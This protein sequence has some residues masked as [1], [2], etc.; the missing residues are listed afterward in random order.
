MTAAGRHIVVGTAGHVDHGKTALVKALT[1]IDTDRWEEE[2]RRGITIDLG[3][4]PLRLKDGSL[5]SMVDVPGH[6]DFVRNMVAGATGID[7]A[8]LVVA[9]DEGMMPQTI[10]HL[11][12]VEYLGVQ[13]GVVAVSKADLVEAEWLELVI[14]DVRQ[15]L[16]ASPISWGTPVTVSAKTMVGIEDLR[17]SIAGAAAGTTA[18]S[19]TDLFR[20]PVD[21]VFSVA[22]AG[23][24]VTGTV[25]AG[26]TKTGDEVLVLPASTKARVRSIEVHGESADVALPG[27]RT[28]L[29]LVGVGRDAV[30]RGSVVVTGQG[31][32]PSRRVD[33]RVSLLET[34][35]PLTQR[36]RVRFHIG[37]AEVLARI[38]P[39]DGA[40]EPGQEGVVR[41]RLEEPVVCR[42][43]DRAVLRSYSPVTTQGGCVVIDPIPDPRPRR[44]SIDP[45][46]GSPDLAKRVSSF[47][48]ARGTRGLSTDEL[49]VRLGIPPDAVPNSIDAATG[50]GV[51]VSG[52]LL[53]AK[54][55]ADQVTVEALEAVRAYHRER[56][57][58]LGLPLEAFRRHAGTEA[59]AD[60]ARDQLVRTEQIVVDRGAVRLTSHEPKL[61][62][63][64]AEF[65]AVFQAALDAAGPRG[66]ALAEIA[67]K[68]PGTDGVEV[69]EYFVRQ[70]TVIRV[71]GD[72]YYSR[73]ALLD[74]AKQTVAH[75]ERVG[76]ASPADLREILGLSRKYLIP[77][78]EWL[79]GQGITV[80]AGDVRRTGPKAH[81]AL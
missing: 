3:F 72:R 20:M 43:G 25:W 14:D 60:Y 15:K 44:P 45:E 36:S 2:K 16:E 77:V 30:Q 27:R 49:P 54:D 73:T 71:G 4:A 32:L 22:G 38:T 31:W 55:V 11:A 58:H 33:V 23:T 29:A 69:A 40:L 34:S 63:S 62:G 75:L 46:R 80:R 41:L 48:R 57:L 6:E 8:L 18:R 59:L 67:D 79:D 19:T 7:V 61:D 28:A 78:L 65:G 53:V 10:E 35:R 76:E 5:V 39:S 51:V 68:L 21:R 81:Q 13:T 64:R 74:V 66:V 24:V 47:V 12:I 50:A 52:T 70:D 26:S 56:P 37:T 1:G 17:E 9:A 42:W